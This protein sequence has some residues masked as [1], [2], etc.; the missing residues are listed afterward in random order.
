MKNVGLSKIRKKQ[1][2]YPYKKLVVPAEIE[3]LGN[4]KLK[5]AMLASV[6]CGGK[7]YTPV[8]AKFNE[9]YDAA[10]AAGHK[11]RNVGDY[12]SFEAQLGLFKERYRPAE[13]RD[14]KDKKKGILLDTQRVK[15]TYENQTWLL[16]NGF[17]P[18]STPG[19]SN[20][21]FGLAIDVGVERKGKLVALA[22][23]KKGAEWMCA[24][25]PE[26]GFYLQS[27]DPSSREFE[28]WHW[29]FAG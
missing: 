22:S 28:I 1:M 25:A 5:P 24:N 2:K 9:L 17:S 18:C 23:D 20:H 3:K 11:L 26:F 10:L 4:G 12:R 7:M 27:D 21:G 8:A 19:K 29:Q 15:R 16:R 13:D 14:W 6:K